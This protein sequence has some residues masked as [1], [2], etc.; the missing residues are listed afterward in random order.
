M[1]RRVTPI[2]HDAAMRRML[3]AIGT[4][5]REG[6]STEEIAHLARGL[7]DLLDRRAAW[8]REFAARQVARREADDA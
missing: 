6:R 8:D 4:L 3:A 5:Q 1:P 7:A 2:Q